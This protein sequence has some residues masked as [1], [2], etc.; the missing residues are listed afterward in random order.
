MMNHPNLLDVRKLAVI[1]ALGPFAVLLLLTLIDLTAPRL[2][3]LQATQQTCSNPGATTGTVP[4][5]SQSCQ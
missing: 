4:S 2:P 1:V 5:S 3:G